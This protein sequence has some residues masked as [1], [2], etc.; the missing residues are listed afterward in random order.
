MRNDQFCNEA[1]AI[2]LMMQSR[3]ATELGTRLMA[4]DAFRADRHKRIFVALRDL[5]REGFP[6][7]SRY[8]GGVI[9]ELVAR[10]G[11]DAAKQARD[12]YLAARRTA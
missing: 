10:C 9:A 11:W 2:G 8:F 12:A 4:P 1:E 5:L 6:I 7:S 3:S